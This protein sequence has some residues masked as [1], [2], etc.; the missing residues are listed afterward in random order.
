MNENATREEP[1]PEETDGGNQPS[2]DGASSETDTASEASAPESELET[3]TRERD[4]Y[5]KHWQRAQADYQNLKRRAISDTDAALRRSQAGLLN[6]IL[7]VLDHL[8]MALTTQCESA[9]AKNLLVGVQMT[10]DQLMAAL[11]RQA[12]TAIDVI[13]A[14]D[15][16]VHQGVAT[17]ATDEHEPGQILD[18]VRSGWM[19]QDLVL[20]FAQVR[21]AARPEPESEPD[22]EAAD[23]AVEG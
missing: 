9:D 4:D 2:N 18:V 3:L 16:A 22:G 14:F 5:L 13:G 17:I 19:H 23:E 6:E 1:S 10:R 8:D 11:K 15:P 21:V 12:V 7:L 20:R